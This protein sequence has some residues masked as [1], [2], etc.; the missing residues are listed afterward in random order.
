MRRIRDLRQRTAICAERL[1]GLS[2][3]RKLSSGYA[4]VTGENGKALRSVEEVRKKDKITI[5]VPDG[6]ILAEVQDMRKE[7]R[8]DGYKGRTEGTEDDRRSL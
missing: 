3:L 4:Y 2:P 1:E 7:N 6:R 8:T 5:Y